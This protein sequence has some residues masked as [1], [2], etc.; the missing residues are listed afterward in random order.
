MAEVIKH[1]L[2]ADSDLLQ[3]IEAGN[4]IQSPGEIQQQALELQ[5]L[6][7]QAIQVKINIVQEDP[8]DKGRRAVLNFGH[9]FANAIERLSHH[10]INHGEAVAMGIVAS[11]HLSVQLGYCPEELQERIEAVLIS[12]GLPTRIPADLG[13]KQLLK[14]MRSDKKKKAGKLRY[15]LLRD[16]GDVFVTDEV[17]E[18]VVSKTFAALRP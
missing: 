12:A 1:S 15:V 13:T 17:P 18:D 16:I 11:T 10:S 9:T 4:W 8:Y 5:A 6:V 14:A 3:K 7:A 2:I